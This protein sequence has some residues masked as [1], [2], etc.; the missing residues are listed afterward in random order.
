MALLEVRNLTMKFG[1]LLANSDVS[2]DVEEGTIV[3]LIGPNGAGKTTLFN[4]VAG[5]YKPVEG[6]VLFDGRDVTGYPS[7]KMARLGLARTFQVVR[8]LKE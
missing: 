5:L 7:W 1:S 6:K 4:C 2:F 3:G 8:P